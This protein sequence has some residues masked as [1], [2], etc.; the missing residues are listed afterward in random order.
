MTKAK[1]DALTGTE[2]GGGREG[3]ADEAADLYEPF[4]RSVRKAA[5]FY[6]VR[7][8]ASS[9]CSTYLAAPGRLRIRKTGSAGGHGIKASLGT[10]GGISRG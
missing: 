7:R 4:R 2:H 9:F 8:S 5:D 1:F 3:A 10:S 6:K